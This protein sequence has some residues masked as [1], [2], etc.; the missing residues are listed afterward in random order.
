MGT[1]FSGFGT[2]H[3]WLVLILAI[4]TSVVSE[5]YKELVEGRFRM[6]LLLLIFS[7]Q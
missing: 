3:F 7:E 4:L 6:I 5:K 1:K 2:Y